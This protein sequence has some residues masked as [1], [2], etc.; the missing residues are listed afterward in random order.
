MPMPLVTTSPRSLRRRPGWLLAVLYTLGLGA[1][2]VGTAEMGALVV[3]AAGIGTTEMSALAL[4]G[5]GIG[6]TEMGALALSAAGIGATELSALA[7]SVAGSGVTGMGAL[8][9]SAMGIGVAHAGQA[10]SADKTPAPTGPTVSPSITT[11]PPASAASNPTA[12]YLLAGAPTFDLTIVKFREQYNSQNPTLPIGEFR[13]VEGLKEPVNLTRAA[14]KINET[15]Y[16]S[17]ALEKGSGKIKTLQLT[18]LPLE[19]TNEKAAR[20][21]AI[22][23]MAALLRQ[24][25]PTVSVEQSTAR[26]SDLLTRG[27]GSRFFQQQWGA[28]RYVV[29][30]NG[31]KG[32]T[33]AIEPVKLALAEP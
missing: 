11:G 21:I 26:I 24:F 31:D 18:Y 28:L 16:A 17:T 22:A 3:S 12:P 1:S 5:S 4:S 10:R 8:A 13:A 33:F 23:Y 30:D 19:G 25:E 27:H 9:I 6:A 20:A 2:G 14:S 7:L 29:A 15:L 32:L